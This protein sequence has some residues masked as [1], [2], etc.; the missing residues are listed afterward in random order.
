MDVSAYWRRQ[1]EQYEHGAKLVKDFTVFDYG[2]IPD[3]PVVRDEC[4]PILNALARFEMS[5]IPNNLAVIGSRGS[6]KT[7]ML[8]HLQQVL[9]RQTNLTFTYVNCRHQN[10][11]FKILAELVDGEIA[12]AS[13][14]DLYQRFILKYSGKT[15]I[16]LDEIDLMSAK[17]KHRE[18]LYFLSRCGKPYMAVLLSN[19]AHLLKQLD[20]ATLSSLQPEVIHFCNYNADQMRQILEDRAKR[21]LHRFDAGILAEIAALTTRKTNA[22]ARV[23]I[24]TLFYSVCEPSR[25]VAA[26]FEQARRDIVVDMVNDLSDPNLRILWAAATCKVD[27]AK[28]I[29]RRYSR[30]SQAAEDKPFSYTHFYANLSY[31]QSNG[32]IALVSTKV[33][34]AYTNR[35]ILTF[36]PSIVE[37]IWQIRS[38]EGV[39]GVEFTRGRDA[40]A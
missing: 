20:A 29:Y 11:S 12:G 27:L 24:K 6:G 31:L 39:G 38:G 35:V 34:R 19:S 5:A 23:A 3:Q 10:T 1:R 30:I 22:D 26:C 18:I 32:L 25:E 16:V 17:D 7:L 33:D 15:V 8:K 28:E 21:G 9:P 37:R 36:D 40:S 13:L 4:K 14:V 2:Y